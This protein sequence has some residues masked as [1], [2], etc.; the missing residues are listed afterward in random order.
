MLNYDKIGCMRIALIIEMAR[1][2]M[3]RDQAR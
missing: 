3:P 1:V 2:K